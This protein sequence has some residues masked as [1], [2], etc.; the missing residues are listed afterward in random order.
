MSSTESATIPAVVEKQ[1]AGTAADSGKPWSSVKVMFTTLT[2]LFAIV[3]VT[4][5]SL[6]PYVKWC[7]CSQNLKQHALLVVSHVTHV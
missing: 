4:S 3:A 6:L 5:H 2:M 1:V 7:M